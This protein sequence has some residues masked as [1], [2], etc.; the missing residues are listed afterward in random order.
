M[1]NSYF[2]KLNNVLG[3][4]WCSLYIEDLCKDRH[5]NNLALHSPTNHFTSKI[6]KTSK[7]VFMYRVMLSA[8]F[9]DTPLSPNLVLSFCNIRPSGCCAQTKHFQRLRSPW[10]YSVLWCI[11]KKFEKVIIFLGG[12]VVR[13]LP[14]QFP[15]TA[16]SSQKQRWWNF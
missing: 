9:M 16:G 11:R 8:I 14:C 7:C 1:S 6:R 15:R 5:L 2:I 4:F 12:G 10:P 3:S 13:C